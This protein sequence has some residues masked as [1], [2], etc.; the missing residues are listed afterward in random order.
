LHA[1]NLGSILQ[2]GDLD[3]YA[4]AFDATWEIDLFGAHRRAVEGA[5]AATQASRASFKD[6]L[7]SLTAE[8]AQNYIELRG[9]QQREAL[10]ERN[11]DIEKQIL[12]LMQL[13]RNGGTVSDL[14]VARIQNQLETT[15]A[16]L[17][18]LK[19]QIQ[20]GLNRL[21][22]LTGR[23]PGSLDQDLAA[24]RSAPLPPES[25]IVGD[26]AGMLR[27]RPDVVMAERKLAEQT[28]GVGQ[29]VAALFPKV[30]LLG[31]LGFTSLS[32]D[33][34]FS[35]RNFSYIAAPLLQ[36]T[37][38]DFGR[39]RARINQAKAQR[40]EAEADYRRT[41][42]AALEDAESALSQYGQQRDTVNV[43]ASAK[44]SAEHVYALTEIRLRGGTASTT[45]VLDADT[46]RVQAELSY[47][48]AI[49]QLSQDYVALQ[50]SLGLG[51]VEPEKS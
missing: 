41:V 48:Q 21:A 15:Q 43:L 2:T 1:G 32:P 14:D 23:V 5:A 51:W 4:V 50:K 20:L 38:F 29:S 34:L 39:N 45:D 17:G 9:A 47:E 13:R 22:M 7:V 26:P 8:V 37:P 36:W 25:M 24:P 3:L 28:A 46:R 12:D 11:I 40:D 31:E 27:R 10:T 16:T 19:A 42:L 44:A 35:A 49:A 6:V 30:T 33:Q 18:P